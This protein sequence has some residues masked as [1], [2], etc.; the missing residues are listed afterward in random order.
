MHEVPVP[1]HTTILLGI[2]AC[3]RSEAIWGEDALEWNPERWLSPLPE[4]VT[5]AHV[6]GVYSNLCALWLALPV[7]IC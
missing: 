6:P 2:R 4:S 1:K 7:D 5:T 3:N